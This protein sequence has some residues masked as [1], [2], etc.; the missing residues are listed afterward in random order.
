MNISEVITSSI[1]IQWGAVDCIHR[2]GNITG[3]SVRYAVQGSTQTVTVSGGGS[4]QTIISGLAP[5]TNYSIEV[6]AV[7]SVSTGVYSN[8]IFQLTQGTITHKILTSITES[9]Y[10]LLCIQFKPPLC[11]LTQ[12]QLPQS[13][14]PGLVLAQWWT[15]MR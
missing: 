2:N 4:T 6:A 10:S 12:E 13:P 11:Q 9:A 7:N 3:Y 8:V 14:F 15:A 1:T 5:S